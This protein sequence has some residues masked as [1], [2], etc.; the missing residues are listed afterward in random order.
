MW[1]I[2]SIDSRNELNTRVW[3]LVCLHKIKVWRQG[4][5]MLHRYEQSHSSR[6]IWRFLYRPCKRCWE[7]SNYEVKIT[8]IIRKKKV[9]G[10]IK[11]QLRRIIMIG[12]V[13]LRPFM[14]KYLTDDGHFDKRKKG[15]KKC[16]A[17]GET[18]FEFYNTFL[19]IK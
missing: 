16:V 12:F 17:K 15:T 19:E 8:L 13:A 14:K 9:I 1:E 6:R 4:R 7:I 3:V 10:L 11:D 18:K 5:T 2:R